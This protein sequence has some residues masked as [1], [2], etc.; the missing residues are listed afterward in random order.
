MGGLEFQ[1]ETMVIMAG[2]QAELWISSTCEFTS[3]DNYEAGKETEIPWAFEISNITP[4]ACLL[5]GHN[6]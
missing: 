5:Q 4:L 3:S 2:R 6:S 1:S